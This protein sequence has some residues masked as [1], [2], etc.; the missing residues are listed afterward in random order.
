M[1]SIGKHKRLERILGKSNKSLIISPIDDSLLAGPFG[2]LENMGELVANISRGH[3]SAI[4]GFR[5]TLERYSALTGGIPTILN[6]TASVAGPRH[7]D[8]V[9]V[10]KVIEAHQIGADAVAAHFNLT[11]TAELSTIRIFSGISEQAR[12]VGLP[13]MAV[14]YPRK[15]VDGLD[16]NYFDLREADEVAYAGLVAHCVRIAAELGADII[17]TQYTGSAETFSTVL[18][19]SQ[20]VPIVVAG[21]PKISKVEAISL[22][23]SAIQSGA[24]GVSFG[25]NVFGRSNPAKFLKTLRSELESY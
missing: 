10:H 6:C 17:K 12:Q 1:F 14:A 11:A 5:G 23:K 20:G 8:K 13:V 16:E 4:L 24:A 19:A 7:S 22:A 18:S 9:Q 21:G 2:G 15:S 25:R 3:P